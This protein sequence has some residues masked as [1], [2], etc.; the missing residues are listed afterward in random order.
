G[1][2]DTNDTPYADLKVEGGKVH[3]LRGAGLPAAL[4]AAG[5]SRGDTVTLRKDGVETVKVKI[6]VPDAQG[7]ERH[8]EERTVERNVWTARLHETIDVRRKR[9]ASESHTPE[10]FR[11]LAKRLGRSGAKTTTL[12]F[13]GEAGY[14]AHVRD[15]ARR[16]GIDALAEVMAETGARARRQLAWLAQ[17]RWQVA[18]LWERAGAALGFAM[19][20][21]RHVSCGDNHCEN[22]AVQ[23]PASPAPVGRTL[24]GSFRSRLPNNEGRRPEARSIPPLLAAVTGFTTPVEVEARARASKAAHHVHNRSLLAETAMR[25]WREPARAVDTIEVLIRKG[26]AGDRIAAAIANDPAAYGALRGSSRLRDRL[27]AVGRE[28]KTALEAVPDVQASVRSLGSSWASAL[29][30]ATTAIAA[31]RQQMATAIPGLSE[32]AGKELRRITTA[33]QK[34]NARLDVLAGSLEPHV[35]RE[36]TSV[37]RA[38]DLR[39]GRSAILR[40]DS[41]NVSRVPPAQR[42]VFEALQDKLKVLQQ[43][44]RTHESQQV[45]AECRQ[46]RLNRE[47]GFY[48]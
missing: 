44:V 35:R 24:V 23:N 33:M 31:E 11:Q 39:F 4:S 32:E 2:E 47:R 43:I 19:D 13:A 27:L 25:I 21:E 5:A 9:V 10:L 40:G 14:Q 46:R 7:G 34:K 38:L 20:R 30:A 3:R 41:D 15:F 28:R 29:K 6:A 37:S 26:I 8:F 17:K 18:M 48:R 42:S 22:P 1:D 45:A 36:F 12:D 16:R